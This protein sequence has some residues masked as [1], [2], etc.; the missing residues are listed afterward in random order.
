MKLL[1]LLASEEVPTGDQLKT[2][3]IVLMFLLVLWER[4]AKIVDRLFGKGEKRELSP[5]PFAVVGH[6]KCVPR[7]VYD[8]H[9]RSTENEFKDIKR[10]M[11]NVQHTLHQLPDKISEKV[12]E[13]QRHQ[14][15]E[16]AARLDR[17]R[18]LISNTASDVSE[19]RGQLRRPRVSGGGSPA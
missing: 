2:W 17:H 14:N 11:E 3:L 10:R 18:D 6:D 15:E 19:L 16:T 4:G 1:I 5:Q 7:S 12:E 13:R 9:R 8:D